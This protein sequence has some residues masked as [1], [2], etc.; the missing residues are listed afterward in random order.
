[1]ILV[2]AHE[3]IRME[4]V[5]FVRNGRPILSGINWSVQRDQSYVIVGPNGCGKTTLARIAALQVHPS[6]GMLRVD[7][8]ELGTFDVRRR[9]QRLAFVSSAMADSIR[10]SLEA[11]DV[12]MCA[13]F[14]ALEPWWHSYTDDDRARARELLGD[15]GIGERANQP[16][17]RLSSGER[18]R[19]LLARSLMVEPDLLILDEP[20]AG[21]DLA[22]REELIASL[23]DLV[24]STEAPAVILVTHHAE[25][26]PPSFTNLLA[27][28]EGTIIADGPLRSTLTSELLSECFDLPVKLIESEVKRK[29]R[30]SA[31]FDG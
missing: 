30:W 6:A 15:Q 17:G 22:G 12:V 13:K 8:D 4:D 26:I 14:A 5:S 10:G 16:F 9:R 7:G 18:Q 20:N 31:L 24:A 2:E 25:E 27:M 23:E 19:C 3:L 29:P 11:Q 28:K 21:L 1:M